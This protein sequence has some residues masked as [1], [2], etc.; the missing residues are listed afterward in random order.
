MLVLDNGD[1]IRGI[2]EVATQ[3]DF[4]VN[5]YVGT[6]ATQLADG[7]MASTEGDLYASGADATVVT[8]ITIVNTDS[9]ARTFTLY[10]K[11]SGGTSRAITPKSLDLG[12]GFSCYVDGQRIVVMDLNGSVVTTLALSDASPNT[13]EPDDSASA[14]TGALASRAD[15]EHAIAGAAPSE[16]ANVQAGAEGTSTSFARADH[17]HQIQ[18]AI[19]DNHLVTIDGSHSSGEYARL[20]ASGLE[21]R[22]VAEMLA[23]ISPLTT[24]G[25]VMFRNAT[26]STRLAKGNS[27]QVLTMGANDPAWAATSSG[28]TYEGGNTTEATTTSTSAVDLLTVSSLSIAATSPIL[29]VL[30]VRKTAGAGDQADIGL[31][32]NATEVIAPALKAWSTPSNRAESG[33]VT[34]RL[35]SRIANYL[36]AASLFVESADGSGSNLAH[37][38]AETADMP[39]ATIT[40][41][42]IRADVN[43]GAITMGADEMHV[44]SLATS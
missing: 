1:A 2:A 4:I 21:G 16:L 23:A 29:C 41:V 25:D 43:D 7:Q 27:G 36:R 24:R 37:S 18:H 12:I 39:T 17:A 9:V 13:I 15:H 42:I 8:S 6:T 35:A 40:D 3:L 20:T 10:L 19:T 33:A 28:L 14:G 30:S 11:P 44:Y 5:G 34:I 31:K 38:A 32:L 22:T 26:V